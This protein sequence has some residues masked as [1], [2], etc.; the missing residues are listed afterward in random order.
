M[1]ESTQHGNGEMLLFARHLDITHEKWDIVA[2]H[3]SHQAFGLKQI[4]LRGAL[5]SIFGGSM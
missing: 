4:A 1:I 5:F 3:S 2:T